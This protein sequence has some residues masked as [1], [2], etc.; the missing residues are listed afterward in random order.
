MSDRRY[1]L[2]V[3]IMALAILA[4]PLVGGWLIYRLGCS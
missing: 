1:N 4:S 2:P 3:A